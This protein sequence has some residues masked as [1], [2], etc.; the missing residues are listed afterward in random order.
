[1]RAVVFDGPGQVDVRE[2]AEPEPRADEAVVRV[3]ACGVCGTDSHIFR[4]EYMADYPIVG[5][6]ELA[7]TVAAV[8]S[9]VAEWREGD[10]V[11]VDPNIFCGAC[12]FCRSNR[13][14]HC[15]HFSAVGVTRDGGFAEYVSAPAR[16]L[17]RVPE[18]LSMEEAALVEPVSCVVY[19][20][21]RVRVLA[22]SSALIFG[23]GPMG[24][25]LLQGLR[26]SGAASVTV[27]DRVASRLELAGRLGAECAVLATGDGPPRDQLRALQPLGFDVVVDATGL[28]KVVEQMFEF[29]KPT[30]KILFFGVCPKGEKAAISPYDVFQNDWEIYGSFALRYTFYPAIDLISSGAVQVR[31]IV[32]HALPLT[33]LPAYMR[34]DLRLEHPGKVLVRP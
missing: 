30:A 24:Q 15:L 19:A 13:A 7:G 27:V 12:Y 5:G 17:Y 32:S 20:L 11:A 4:G 3:A 8:G 21:Q 6:H 25:L 16:N 9:G 1:M 29:A 2:V 22:G 10:R 14:N 26:R 34:G 28:P 33:D 23:A 31:P 18:G